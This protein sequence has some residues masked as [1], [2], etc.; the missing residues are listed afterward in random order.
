MVQ[1]PGLPSEASIANEKILST[2]VVD[3]SRDRGGGGNGTRKPMDG[4][5]GLEPIHPHGK[6]IITET[7]INFKKFLDDVRVYPPSPMPRRARQPSVDAGGDYE[8]V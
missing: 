8:V 7:M 4:K 2:I 6:F 1:A 5:P 3:I